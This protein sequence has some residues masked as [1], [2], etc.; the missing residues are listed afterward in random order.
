MVILSDFGWF[1]GDFVHFGGFPVKMVF[2]PGLLGN[3]SQLRKR[4]TTHR[5]VISEVLQRVD[6]TLPECVGPKLPLGRTSEMT[7]DELAWIPMEA[8]IVHHFHRKSPKMPKIASKRDTPLVHV[9]YLV[10]L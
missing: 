8:R 6:F 10:H 2:N 7:S 1:W 4:Y 3:P 5:G 9:F